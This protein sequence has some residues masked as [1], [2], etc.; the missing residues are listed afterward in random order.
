MRT[1]QQKDTVSC[2]LKICGFHA[3]IR[4]P[5]KGTKNLCSTIELRESEECTKTI[6]NKRKERIENS[7]EQKGRKI[8]NIN[9]LGAVVCRGADRGIRTPNRLITSELLYR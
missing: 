5:I 3:G 4:T 2:P 1:I 7:P 8:Y 9:R 6:I